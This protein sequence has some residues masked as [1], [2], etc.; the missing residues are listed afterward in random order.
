MYVPNEGSQYPQ[1]VNNSVHKKIV[2]VKFPKFMGATDGLSA[3][4][5]L[6]NIAMCFTL[7][8]YTS[9]MKV[10]MV[11]FQLKGSTLLG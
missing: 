2:K 5:W 9:D 7:R 6:D 3:E 10:S 1:V 4:A 8:D 11:V